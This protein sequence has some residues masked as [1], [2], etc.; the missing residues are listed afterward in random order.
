MPIDC[1]FSG[2]SGLTSITIGNGIKSMGYQSFWDTTLL[3]NIYIT[4]VAV[5]CYIDGLDNLMGWCQKKLYLNNELIT[6][7]VIPDGVTSIGNSAFRYYSILTSIIIPNSVTSI[8]NAAFYDCSLTSVNIPD[9]VTSIGNSAFENCDKLTSVTIGNG[10][11]SIGE[12]VFCDCSLTSINIPDSVTSIGYYAFGYCRKLTYNE[13]DNGLYL[14]NENNPYLFLMNTKSN[15]ITSCIINENCKVIYYYAFGYCSSLTSITIPDRVTSIEYYAFDGCSSLTSVTIGD[16][17]ASISDYAF[18]G[19]IGLKSITVLPD[20]SKYHS[21]GNCLIETESKK[22]ISGCKK[23]IIPTDGSVTS[24][25]NGAFIGLS[26]LTSITIPNS[27]NNIGN[28][29]FSGC[30]GLTN[31][32]IPDSVTSIGESAFTDCSGLTNIVIPD[33]VTSIGPYTFTGCSVIKEIHYEGTKEQWS[34]LSKGIG[35]WFIWNNGKT[36][37]VYFSDGTTT[38]ITT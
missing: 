8:G 29:A 15:D 4:D 35:D 5:W 28:Y 17:V 33:S 38:T 10:V 34:Y 26:S 19:C 31:I 7:L 16:G 22:L 20:N 27:V 18:A 6:D 9:S 21:D 11:T 12:R 30:S 37:T 32:V 1:A 3:T 14:G 24:I 36:I 13:Y 2:C 25:G 23:S